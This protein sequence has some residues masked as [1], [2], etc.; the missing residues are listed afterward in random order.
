[1]KIGILQCDDVRDELLAEHQNYP[2]MFQE[3]FLAEDASL[4]FETYRVL[5]GAFPESTQACDVWLITGSRYGVYDDLPWIPKL[6]AFVQKLFKEKR[7]LVGICFGH[8]LM[9]EALGGQVT[10][11]D[12][13]WGVGLSFNE[14]SHHK[15]WMQPT[16]EKL[17]LLVSHQDQVVDLPNASEV[18]TEVLASSDFCPY[19]MVQYGEHFLSIQ[20]HPEFSPAYSKALM[21]SRRGSIPEERIEA[22]INSLSIKPDRELSTRWLINFLEH[23]ESE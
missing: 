20:G 18:S 22:G 17:N 16:R 3:L 13:G 9:A 4:T 11:S 1:M 15:P 8:Q 7:K 19:Y 21:L 14:V 12:K 10:R 2:E 6:I 23:R 5:D